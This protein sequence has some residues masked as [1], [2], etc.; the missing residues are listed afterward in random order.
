MND[1][2]LVEPIQSR[3]ELWD[4]GESHPELKGRLVAEQIVEKLLQPS[5]EADFGKWHKANDGILFE[6]ICLHLIEK[7]SDEIDFQVRGLNNKRTLTGYINRQKLL[8]ISNFKAR[9]DV[10][11]TDA[12]GTLDGSA[13]HF[14]NVSNYP[15][16]DAI[17]ALGGPVKRNQ[18]TTPDTACTLQMT[19]AA[20]HSVSDDGVDILCQINKRMKLDNKANAKQGLP[21]LV[22]ED[23]FS[24]FQIQ[25]AENEA[26]QAA[27]DDIEEIVGC[28]KFK[29]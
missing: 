12:L 29:R 10:D 26:K 13:T 17:L 3:Q 5:R 27:L 23:N 21:F 22:P 24:L 9:K 18:V 2:N 15:G 6:A 16:L 28:I 11:S 1:E 7:H 8:D 14:L 4:T 20:K 25:K 19:R